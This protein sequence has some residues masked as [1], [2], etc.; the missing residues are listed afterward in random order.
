MILLRDRV[1]VA[2]DPILPDNVRGTVVAVKHDGFIVE[3]DDPLPVLRAPCVR[4]GSFRYRL[5]ASEHVY[6]EES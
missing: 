6:E 1:R 3:L 5:V 2:G 4:F